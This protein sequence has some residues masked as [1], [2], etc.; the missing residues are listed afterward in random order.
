MSNQKSCCLA[1]QSQYECDTNEIRL[2]LSL[3]VSSMLAEVL[4]DGVNRH[5]EHPLLYLWEQKYPD[6]L[7]DL[8][9][10]CCIVLCYELSK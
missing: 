5:D 8:S 9:I 7:Q 4:P 1:F 10:G 2:M 3:L 6:L